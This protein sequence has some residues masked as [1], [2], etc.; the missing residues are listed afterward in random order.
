[1]SGARKPFSMDHPIVITFLIFAIIAFMY[2]AAE[3]L[4][5]LALAVLL[6]FALAPLASFLE[7]RGLPKFIAAVVT[8]LAVLTL[9]GVVGFKVGQ[10]LDGLASQLPKLENN[11][12][13]K[14]QRF[15]MGKDG[16]FEKLN[17]VVHDVSETID[18]RPQVAPEQIM[19]VRV[20]NNRMNILAEIAQTAGPYLLS[21]GGLAF[22]LILVLFI[23]NNRDDLADRMIRLFGRGKISLTTKTSAEVGQR[24]SRYLLTFSLVNSCVG[25][26]IAAGLWAIGM[27]FP[28]V[29][30]VLAGLL[31]FIPYAGP[32][33][34]FALPFIF[35]L[36]NF[37]GWTGPLEVV[38]LFL[39]L[40]I[41]ANS[42]LEPMIY[43]R[44]TGVSSLGLL[45]AAMFWAWLWG[46]MGLLLSTPL[47]VCLAVMGKY[48]P[49]LKFFATFL[50]EET[51]LR[52][53]VRFYQRLLARDHDGAASLADEVLEKQSRAVLFDEIFIPTLSMVERDSIRDDIEER[54]RD[55][56]WWAVEEIL[57]DLESNPPGPA[58]ESPASPAV[59]ETGVPGPSPEEGLKVMG[60]APNDRGDLLA[61]R[62]LQVLLA[63]SGRTIELTE[64]GETPLQVAERLASESPDL[65]VVSHLPPAGLTTT[66]YLVRRLRARFPNTS[67]LVGR[68]S[69]FGEGESADR[70]TSAGATNVVSTLAEARDRIL[71]RTARGENKSA[72]SRKPEPVGA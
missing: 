39:T 72:E 36:A 16:T 28:L 65:I 67:I 1:V 38:A 63:P 30:G 43:G 27:P 25:I 23:L 5:P 53:D 20:I 64:P 52:P 41:V 21:I 51:P 33:T 37:T 42:F 44:T 31:R 6:A 46:A 49:S 56:A 34:A 8:V 70:L 50:G 7:R 4:K 69:E 58:D 48:V 40:E 14:L 19:D 12:L 3:V 35:S 26:V 13:S 29:W 45:V 47:T 18:P 55:F 68:W 57:E 62:M 22:V 10:Q 11:I 59:T 54:Q 9:I 71:G 32:A 60:V 66:R 61:L 2:F 17:Q 24:I 15:R